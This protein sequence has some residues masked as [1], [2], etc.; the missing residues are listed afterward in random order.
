MAH[1]QK[2]IKIIF[3]AVLLMKSFVLIINLA[4]ELFF[5]EE[6]NAV[7]RF[8]EAILNEYDY[9]P[10]TIIISSWICDKLFDVGDDKLGDH[11]HITGKYRGARHWICN[12]NLKLAKKIPAIFHNLRDYDRHLIIK[13][14]RKFDVK[15]SVITSGLEKYM[16][17]TINLVF[18][19]SM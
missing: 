2:N 14:I 13:E 5:T 8:I 7:Y 1:T 19:D 9:F 17:F 4:R 18:I 3:L 10:K 16:A 12:I 6:E 15:V 11:C